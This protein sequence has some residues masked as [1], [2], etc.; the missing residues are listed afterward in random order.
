MLYGIISDIHANQEALEE[1][2]QRLKG[3]VDKIICLGDIIGYGP[4]PNECCEMIRELNI[5][6]IAG[7]HEKAVLGELELTWFNQNARSALHWTQK[8]LSEDNKNFIY[9]LPNAL[10]YE[11]F[12]IVH[13]SLIN[14]IE[15]YMDSLNV[16]IPS[17]E[18]MAKNLLLV[19]H[20]HMPIFFTRKTDGNYDGGAITGDENIYLGEYDR[21][22][23][24]V[25]S[26]GQ[27]RD[28]DPRAAYGILND[29]KAEISVHRIS[30]DIAKTQE[31]MRN[32]LLPDS[33]IER[34]SLGN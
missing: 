12:Q 21:V 17:F 26:V 6:S 30:Y 29:E 11:K 13:G 15:E 33:L 28:G 14:P 8:E 25:G 4:N 3:K 34:L 20:T 22:I 19:G 16:A 31:K 10:V 23:V 32:A 24:N 27:P 5:P 7:N 2:L 9:Q 1:C 18:K